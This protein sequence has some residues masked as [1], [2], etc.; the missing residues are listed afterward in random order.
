MT[1]QEVYIQLRNTIA[2]RNIDPSGI[3][4][5]PTAY[6][7]LEMEYMA[8]GYPPRSR[9]KFFGKEIFRSYDVEENEVKFIV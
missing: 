1:I 9:M 5:H 4:V 7:E 8:L 2:H 3:L 6:M